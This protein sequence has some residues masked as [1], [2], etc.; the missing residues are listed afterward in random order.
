MSY[1]YSV[2]YCKNNCPGHY[3]IIS[4]YQ[5]MCIDYDPNL[6]YYVYFCEKNCKGHKNTKSIDYDTNKIIE[7]SSIRSS[8]LFFN[9][10]INNAIKNGWIPFGGISVTVERLPVG[11]HSVYAEKQYYESHYTKARAMVKYQKK[12]LE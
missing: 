5:D 12:C 8:S 6:K 4:N 7:Y 1:P 9:E 2:T 10:Q 3:G 11:S